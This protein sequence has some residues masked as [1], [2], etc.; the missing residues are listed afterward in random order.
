[1]VAGPQAASALEDLPN[2]RLSIPR[3]ATTANGGIEREWEYH[4]P[5]NAAKFRT[6]YT[7]ISIFAGGSGYCTPPSSP[8]YY[9]YDTGGCRRSN[10][11]AGSRSC[12]CR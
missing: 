8:D 3:S 7:P 1:L 12:G 10:C 11:F 2:P 6:K 4:K 5:A 9:G